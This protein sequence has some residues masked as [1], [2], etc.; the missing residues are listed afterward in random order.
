MAPTRA[1]Q[2][3]TEKLAAWPGIDYP[4]GA[5]WDGEGTN[6]SLF[7]ENAESVDLILFDEEGRQTATYELTERTDLVWHGYVE[8]V[9]PGQRYGYRVHG[10]YAR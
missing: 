9:A 4:L 10:R 3:E 5:T 2:T 7:A 6:F 8:K 1:A